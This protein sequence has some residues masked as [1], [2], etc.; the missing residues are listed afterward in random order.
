MYSGT[1]SE[2]L[3]H[4]LYSTLEVAVSREK[5]N[6]PLTVPSH[7]G[8]QAVHP[9][10]LFADKAVEIN[11]VSRRIICG[12]RNK[13]VWTAAIITLLVVVI[14]AAVGG[15]LGG[16][17]AH[18]TSA[19]ASPTSNNTSSTS[20]SSPPSATGNPTLLA[21]SNL[22]AASWNQTQP[23]GDIIMQSRLYYQDTAGNI[24]ESAWN[25]SARSWYVSN[26]LGT[27]KQGSPI[28]VAATAQPDSD[29]FVSSKHSLFRVHLLKASLADERVLPQQYKQP[30]RVVYK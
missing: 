24:K 15:V 12:F 6:I 29:F 8:L 7:E 11:G 4:D 10:V 26:L 28:T 1:D 22:A 23:S 2:G 27:A 17:K 18:Q 25:S 9:S 14:V 16:R 3:Q 20:S 30:P 13:I 5:E 21:A 19:L